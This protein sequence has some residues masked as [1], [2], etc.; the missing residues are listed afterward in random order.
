MGGH[1]QEVPTGRDQITRTGLP[2]FSHVTRPHD[3]SLAVDPGE[4][5][6]ALVTDAL[7]GQGWIQIRGIGPAGDVHTP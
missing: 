2:G 6:F 4:V 3:I 5:T 7:I 1:P